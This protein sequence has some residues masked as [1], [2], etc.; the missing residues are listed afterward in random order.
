MAPSRKI[1]WI[2]PLKKHCGIAGYSRSL[3]LELKEQQWDIKEYSPPTNKR[4]LKKLLANTENSLAVH[5]QYDPSFWMTGR[6]CM[7]R[8][9]SKK[10]NQSLI[11]TLHEV[12]R[13]S[14]FDYP[15]SKIFSRIPG[16]TSIKKWRYRRTHPN[17]TI[18]QKL[19]SSNY[20]AKAIQIHNKY[21]KEI[22]LSKGVEQNKLFVIPHGVWKLAPVK[23]RSAPHV[24]KFGTFGFINPSVNY[25]TVLKAL[26]GLNIKWEYIIGGGTR[27]EEHRYLI[28]NIKTL[29]EHLGI[30][31]RVKITGYLEDESIAVFFKSL[32]IYLAP[33]KFKSSSS[34]LNRAISFGLPVIA[35][36]IPLIDEINSRLNFITTYIGGNSQSLAS[37]VNQITQD[38]S[39]RTAIMKKTSLYAKKYSFKEEAR[40]ISR[41]Y[42]KLISQQ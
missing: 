27:L 34:S 23:L 30:K 12:Y 17:F 41:L 1:A 6:A 10:L 8:Q 9:F 28:D 38:N 2:Y 7:F 35:S 33:F 24:W 5:V 3:I 16:I 26:S 18:E 4:E 32:D 22:L 37:A 11:V 29:A 20:F 31:D 39:L 36:K 15:Y 14:P 40:Q 19:Y 13:E 21:Q 25:A 42:Y